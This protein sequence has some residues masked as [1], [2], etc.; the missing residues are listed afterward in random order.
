MDLLEGIDGI[1]H[2]TV[3]AGSGRCRVV[4]TPKLAAE[5]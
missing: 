4:Q 5:L 2:A 1:E 3:E